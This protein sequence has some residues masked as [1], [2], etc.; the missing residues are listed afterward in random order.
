MQT[1]VQPGWG[2][3]TCGEEENTVDLAQNGTPIRVQRDVDEEETL[4][5]EYG[6][7]DAKHAYDDHCNERTHILMSLLAAPSRKKAPIVS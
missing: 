6:I 1:L 7:E 5:V 2:E 4:C 3:L